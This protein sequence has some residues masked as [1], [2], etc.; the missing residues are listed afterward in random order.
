LNGD[1]DTFFPFPNDTDFRPLLE[2]GDRV[3]ASTSR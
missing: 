2:T 3:D 1:P